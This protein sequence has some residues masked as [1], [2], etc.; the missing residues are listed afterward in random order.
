[1]S[2]WQHAREDLMAEA[3][4]LVERAELAVEG[5]DGPVVVGFRRGGQATLMVGEDWVLQFDAV[6]ALRRAY[7][8]GRLV[9]AERQR[10]VE[11]TWRRDA[12]A[13]VLL[14]HEM[15]DDEQEA[16]LGRVRRTLDD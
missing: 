11:L 6:G 14:R 2:R 9:K 7:D 5:W 8:A 4:G 1:M 15:S 12:E 10:L 16:F 3:T 13:S